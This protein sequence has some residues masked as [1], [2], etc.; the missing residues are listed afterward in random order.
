LNH[1]LFL[2][3]G[4]SEF[5]LIAFVILL[6]FG[7]KGVPDIARSLGRASREF[8]DAMNGIEREL[9]DAASPESPA[10]NSPTVNPPAGTS[11]LG[12]SP[13][14]TALAALPEEPKKAEEPSESEKVGK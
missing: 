14:A 4:G 9:R 8:K 7:A 13:T 2:N 5:L 6:F 12:S 10:T 11:P 1:I 3:I